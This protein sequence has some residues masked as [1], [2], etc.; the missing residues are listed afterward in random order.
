MY[1]DAGIIRERTRTAANTWIP[2]RGSLFDGRPSPNTFRLAV[3]VTNWD[4]SIMTQDSFVWNPD[5][6]TPG[7]DNCPADINDDSG[8]DGDDVIRFFELWDAGC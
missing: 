1:V 3:S 8:V 5:G 4:P 2:R 6:E 7:E